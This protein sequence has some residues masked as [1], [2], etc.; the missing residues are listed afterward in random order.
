[1]ILPVPLFLMV[2]VNVYIHFRIWTRIR[3]PRVTDPQ[4]WFTLIK[5]AQ[6]DEF[7]YPFKLKSI[8]CYRSTGIPVVTV[9]VVIWNFRNRSSRIWHK[10]VWAY[11]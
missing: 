2:F 9:P 11:M 4:H 1:M 5:S 10:W 3:N 8:Q 7:Y 6:H